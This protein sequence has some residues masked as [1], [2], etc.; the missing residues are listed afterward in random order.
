MAIRRTLI[1]ALM[2]AILIAVSIA[3]S[4]AWYRPQGQSAIQAEIEKLVQE[5]DDAV[6]LENNYKAA[7]NVANEILGL[8]SKSADSQSVKVRGL[9]R[10]AFAEIAFGNWGNRWRENIKT[11]QTLVSQEPTID[12]AEFLLYLGNIRG[13]WQS[14]FD[15]G[16]EKI[17]EAIWIANHIK[18]DRTL[19]LAYAKLSK[20]HGFLEQSNLV[21]QNAYRSVAV[22]KSYG[23]KSIV[24]TTLQNLI[25]QLIYL[26][27]IPEA[28][29]FGNQLL[30]L[31]PDADYAMN[32]LFL[33]NES[34]QFE[35]YVD[36]RIEEVTKLE[37]E[38]DS[39]SP[40]LTAKFG[41]L[42]RRSALAYLHRNKF[43]K[44]RERAELA[45]PYLKAAGDNHSLSTCTRMLTVTQLEKA[46]DV[47]KVDKIAAAFGDDDEFPDKALAVAY[48]KVG[49]LEKSLYWKERVLELKEKRQGSEI[50][51]LRQSSELY[52]ESEL[53]LR[54]QTA[55]GNEIVAKSTK[56]VWMLGTVLTLG[57]TVV[58]LLGCF[59][60]LLRRERNSLEA[61]VKSRTLSLSKAMQKANAAD[62]AKSDFLAQINHEI[63][64]PLTAILSYCDLLS[65]NPGHDRSSEFVA[66]IE[67]SSQHLRK[68]VDEILEVSKIESSGLE[69]E[70]IEFYPEQTVNDINGIMAEQATQ[71][72]LKLN[73]IF[74]GSKKLSIFSDE[75][76]IRQ[77]ALNLIGNA[78]KFTEDGSVNASF[79]LKEHD[80]VNNA[81]L[82][83]VVNDSG[84]GIPENETSS[85]F[86]RFTKASNGGVRDGS[87]LG[88]YIVRQL[89][90]CLDGEITMNSELGVGTKTI[91]SL[92]VKLSSGSVTSSPPK[93]DW[94]QNDLEDSS[95]SSVKRILVVEDQEMIRTSLKLQLNASGVDCETTEDLKRTIEIVENWHPNLVL[96]DLRM[97]KHSGFEVL[98]QIRQSKNSSIPVYAITGDATDVVRQK[99][100]SYGFDGFVTKPFK[101][102]TILEVLDSFSEGTPGLV[103]Q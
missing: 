32:V 15:E 87:G 78:I 54:K 27:K 11:C 73:C 28:A 21:A 29:E 13:K 45:M 79:E 67:S 24:V 60:F 74:A 22:A 12:R 61:L 50:G 99:C 84:I 4:F 14:R 59:Y 34:N 26:D 9:I 42:L 39:L 58:A 49:E 10:L 17:Q 100:L 69:R 46:D 6:Y 43:S 86:D 56:R 82:I 103:S 72:G 91:V 55:L 65:F 41:K 18:D 98:K 90:S 64:N 2:A 68:L 71:K 3:V 94:K 48:A 95:L 8:S 97:P 40:R 1:F 89:V 38:G 102:S 31:K 88:L 96:L 33:A 35:V 101:I 25:S 75:T 7:I 76:K 37:E 63:R 93:T 47:E 70:Y 85:I 66:G 92:P 19:S 53:R 62:K 52:W 23:R 30:K 83:I 77:I 44:C 20:M 57:L 16:L 36:N 51:F 5:Y 80:N 81:K